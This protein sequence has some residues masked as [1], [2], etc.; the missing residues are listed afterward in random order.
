MPVRGVVRHEVED[1]LQAARM[2]GRNERIEIGKIAEQRMDILVVADVVAEVGH[3]R[4]IDRRDPKR[5]DA[6]IDEMA[7]PRLNTLQIADPIT[8]RILERARIDLIDD[9]SLPP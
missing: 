1:D 8:V 7:E 6:Q 3:R 2:R 4:G 9:S 5:V